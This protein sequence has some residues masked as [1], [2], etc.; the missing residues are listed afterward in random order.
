MPKARWGR[1]GAGGG[2]KPGGV[3]GR[4]AARA[5]GNTERFRTSAGRSDGAE[6]TRG[7]HFT[8]GE[9]AMERHVGSCRF[10]R[11]LGGFKCPKF[12]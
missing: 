9:A 12:Y 4:T 10:R 8:P 1:L 3:T 11:S 2:A 7:A 6:G 5:G